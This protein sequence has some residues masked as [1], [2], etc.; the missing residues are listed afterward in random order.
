[1]FLWTEYKLHYIPNNYINLF[2]SIQDW[3]MP[4]LD[5]MLM[6]QKENG[7]LWTPSKVIHRL[8]L[9]IDN[10]ESIYYWAAKNKI[11]VFSPALTDGSLGDMFFFHSYKNP[12][13]VIDIVSDLSL[14]HI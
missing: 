12:G 3:I 5:K 9:E 6:E 1:M 14:I 8:G 11:P 7:T 4:I 10:K 13:L 2:I